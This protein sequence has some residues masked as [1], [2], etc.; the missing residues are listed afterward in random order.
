MGQKMWKKGKNTF[1]L[2]IYQ[3]KN[4]HS[5]IDTCAIKD[6]DETIKGKK[7]SKGCL[8]KRLGKRKIKL[9]FWKVMK[10]ILDGK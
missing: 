7:R 4:L 10:S 8:G 3:S 9:L 5:Y 2:G 1:E 6:E